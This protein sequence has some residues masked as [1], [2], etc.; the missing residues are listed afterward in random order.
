MKTKLLAVTM[1][2]L[3]AFGSIVGIASANNDWTNAGGFGASNGVKGI[4]V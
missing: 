1:M 3:A 2:G 4:G